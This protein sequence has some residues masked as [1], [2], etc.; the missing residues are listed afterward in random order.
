M[1]KA[2]EQEVLEMFEAV[3]GKVEGRTGC[4]VEVVYGT[5]GVDEEDEILAVAVMKGE[6]E[7]WRASLTEILFDLAAQGRER[8]KTEGLSTRQA[9][10][11][12]VDF[13]LQAALKE[14]QDKFPA[15]T[16][17]AID[18]NFVPHFSSGDTVDNAV[19]TGSQ[20]TLA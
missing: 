14:I 1:L 4:Y 9:V 17:T 2:T 18:P 5:P 8:P 6:R 16:V 7:C 19:Y 11:G 12:I 20:V 15:E 3:H 13:H 10:E